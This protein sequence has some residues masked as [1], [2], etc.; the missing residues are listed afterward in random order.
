MTDKQI[1]GLDVSQCIYFRM[2]NK[3]PLCKACNSGVGSPY[4]ECHKDCY[5]KQLKRKEQECEE[6]KKDLHQN[7]KEKDKLHLIIDRLLEASGYDTDTA[8]AE[9]FEDVYE[10]MRYKQQQLN[11][12]KAENEQAEQKLE[13]IREICKP[14]LLFRGYSGQCVDTNEFTKLCKELAKDILQI[15]SEVEDD[16]QD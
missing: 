1:D 14:Y 3:M 12:L 6:L 16:R 15:I 9:D 8:S 7:F 10:H 13:R 2:N 11:Q 4:C 5:Y